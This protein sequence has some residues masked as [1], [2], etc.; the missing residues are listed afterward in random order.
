[1]VDEVSRTISQSPNAKEI[2]TWRERNEPSFF[3]KANPF[4]SPLSIT[5]LGR[6]AFSV[7]LPTFFWEDQ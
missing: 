3:G 7:V 5:I 4:L 6:S 1:M 2:D